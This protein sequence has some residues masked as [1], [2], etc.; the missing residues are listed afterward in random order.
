MLADY[1][2]PFEQYTSQVKYLWR[3][4]CV[5]HTLMMSLGLKLEEILFSIH[6]KL[7][8]VRKILMS[9]SNWALKNLWGQHI[10][11]YMTKIFLQLFS[12][13]VAYTCLEFIVFCTS[14]F[15]HVISSNFE[16][17]ARVNEMSAQRAHRACLPLFLSTC[18]HASTHL[19]D[20]LPWHFIFANCTKNCQFSLK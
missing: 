6:S 5:I 18:T 15:A 7:I 8:A 3:F 17:L 12:E 4:Q 10:F 19:L 20:G 9:L 13:R 14:G 16:F 1:C 11:V 2:L